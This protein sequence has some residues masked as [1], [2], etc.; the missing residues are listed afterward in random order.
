VVP[1]PEP[2]EIVEES[3]I[4][5]LVDA[6]VLVIA[7]GGGGIPVVRHGQ[8]VTGVEAVVDK[9]LASALLA[10]QLRAD[11]LVLA[12]DVDRIYLD[13][14]TPNACGLDAVTAEDLRR[15]AAA[16]HFPAGS[17]GPKVEAALRFVHAG[18]GEAIVT[19]YEQL[20]WALQGRAGTRVR[21]AAR[22]T[23]GNDALIDARVWPV[24]IRCSRGQL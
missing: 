24:D 7:L 3:V 10:T 22:V 5:A 12:T 14:G 6:N 4:R 19:S 20:A 8:R 13:F 1:S 2:L 15:H 21:L 17:M 23:A 16:G 9:D 18:G 11:R